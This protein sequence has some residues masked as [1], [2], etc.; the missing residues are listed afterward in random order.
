MNRSGNESQIKRGFR[1]A[2]LT[3]VFFFVAVLFFGGMQ[4]VFFPNSIDSDSFIG[5][6]HSMGWGLLIGSAA[7]M[8]ITVQGWARV[9]AGLLALAVLNGM[10]SFSTGHLMANPARPISRLD[11]L[12][13]TAFF[14]VAAGLASTLK[15]RKLNVVDRACVL[16]FVFIFAYLLEFEGSQSV[17]GRIAPLHATDFALMV[18]A[19]SCLLLVYV[20]DYSERRRGH[21][22]G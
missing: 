13:V 6:H 8:A 12:Y 20:L 9:L 5:H 1:M 3:L 14:A 17:G 22:R 16:V 10:L 4:I 15:G 21:V 2:A 11:A 18:A 19:L 7:I